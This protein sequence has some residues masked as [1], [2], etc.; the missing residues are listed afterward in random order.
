MATNGLSLLKLTF[1]GTSAAM[2]TVNRNVSGLAV[3]ADGD[4]LLFD[5]GEGSQ[6]QMIKFGTGFNVA[7][8]FFTHFHLDHYLGIIGFLRTLG[9]GGRV[10][11]MTLYGPLGGKRLLDTAL[12][13]GVEKLA[14]PV[15]I[16]ELKGGEEFQRDGY[17][18]KAVRVEHRVYALGYVL[19]EDTKPGRF[20]AE[21]ARAL[22]VQAGPD[23]GR[24]QKGESVTAADGTVVKP[25]QVLGAARAG[26]KVCISGD[27]RPCAAL[28]A[29]AQGAD[30]LVH[31]ATFTD[32]EQERALETQHSTARESGRVAREANVKR[33]VLTHLS[34]RHDVD[35]RPIFEHARAEFSGPVDVAHDG[36]SI[37]LSSA[38]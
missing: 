24:L 16:I 9:M 23:F 34:S 4:L 14:F 22:G 2:P 30:L 13:L 20:D 10:E 25:E 21:A 28:I 18:I 38:P 35:T 1:L 19:Q 15:E 26:R 12:H 29:A 7:A 5:C 37:E 33:L 3:K 6:R 36:F 31:E 17:R 27:T 11:P 8:V 32:D